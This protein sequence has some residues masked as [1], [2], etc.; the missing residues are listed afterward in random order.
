MFTNF[1]S[2]FNPLQE[3]EILR[4]LIRKLKEAAKGKGLY[5]NQRSKLHQ[6]YELEYGDITKTG[7][8][9]YNLIYFAERED[10]D[11]REQ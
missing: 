9:L 4:Y 7:R 5:L 8:N 3:V 1:D 10:N 11:E 6:E 2:S